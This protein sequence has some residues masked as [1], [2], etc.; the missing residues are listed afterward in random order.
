[1]SAGQVTH[2]TLT[3][4][5]RTILDWHLAGSGFSAEVRA[6]AGGLIA[7]TLGVYGA[8]TGHLRPT[9]ARSHYTFNLRDVARVVQARGPLRTLTKPYRCKSWS[10]AGQAHALQWL[11]RFQST[12]SSC[13]LGYILRRKV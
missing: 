13:T 3:L 6:L 4:I 5:F 9:P 2:D 8:A 11:G 7:A 10:A 12:Q 1:M